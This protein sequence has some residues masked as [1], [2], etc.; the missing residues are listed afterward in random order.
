MLAFS[1]LDASRTGVPKYWER[2]EM[3]EKKKKKRN[4]CVGLFIGTGSLVT[5][6]S[7][8][9]GLKGAPSSKEGMKLF[10]K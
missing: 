4:N 10:T 8:M 7:I 6:D 1:E 3:L 5:G 2:C 9:I